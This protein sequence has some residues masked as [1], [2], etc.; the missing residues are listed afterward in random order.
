VTGPNPDTRK[1]KKVNNTYELRGEIRQSLSDTLVRINALKRLDADTNL[2]ELEE[3][4]AENYRSA[5]SYMAA[6]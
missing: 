1:E 5:L 2:I 4:R 6:E 3:L